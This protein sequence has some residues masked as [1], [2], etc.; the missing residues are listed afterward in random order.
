MWLI[1]S[2]QAGG[3]AHTVATCSLELL[4]CRAAHSDAIRCVLLMQ[5]ETAADPPPSQFFSTWPF[6]KSR[7]AQE[8]VGV[9]ATPTAHSLLLGCCKASPDSLLQSRLLIEN[10]SPGQLRWNEAVYKQAAKSV[11]VIVMCVSVCLF[12]VLMMPSECLF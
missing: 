3:T 11:E 5:Q 8:R 12:R 10:T 4:S 9:L 7:D 6:P 2:L 1:L